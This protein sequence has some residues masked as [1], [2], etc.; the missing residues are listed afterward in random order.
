[1]ESWLAK[2]QL[3][4]QVKRGSVL[5]G[6]V[7]VLEDYHIRCGMNELLITTKSQSPSHYLQNA[8]GQ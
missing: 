1:M 3:G 4:L 7:C 6:L 8:S 2:S 5:T